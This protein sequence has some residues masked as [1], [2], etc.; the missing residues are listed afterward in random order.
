M[1][2]HEND[3]SNSVH[4]LHVDP[5]VLS[6]LLI[7]MSIFDPVTCTCSTFIDSVLYGNGTGCIG[8]QLLNVSRNRIRT[9]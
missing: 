7:Y 1:E 6:E 5:L 9:K 3:Y 4:V 8:L 2:L